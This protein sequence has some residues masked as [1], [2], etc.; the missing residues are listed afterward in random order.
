M[1][2][3]SPRTLEDV[4]RSGDISRFRTPQS[5]GKV[6]I[7]A[8]ERPGA[9]TDDDIALLNEYG[10]CFAE[11]AFE[12]REKARA[13]AAAPPPPPAPPPAPPIQI[14]RWLK[15]DTKADFVRRCGK[16]AVSLEFMMTAFDLIDSVAA[17]RF[18]AIDQK[19]IER[20]TRLTS[21]ETRLA[22]DEARLGGHNGSA[23]D[24]RLAAIER[25][26]AEL[27]SQQAI[28]GGRI[29]QIEG[30]PSAVAYQ[31]VYTAGKTYQ[32]GQFATWGGSLWHCN[33][34]T[35]AKPGET[36]V[37]SRAW[38]LAVKKGTDGKDAKDLK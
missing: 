6:E 28:D 19:N 9:L 11:K 7:T 29:K 16:Q 31:G 8:R 25:A 18:K 32:R 24:E 13:V 2:S 23:L 5:V 10:R 34:R 30:Q 1:T 26:L 37:A 27:R 21:I 20:N 22:S 15:G 33:E 4:L 12:A 3:K 17:E 36:S 35:T 14:A 38:V